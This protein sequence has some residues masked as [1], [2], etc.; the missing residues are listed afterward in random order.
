[1]AE[2]GI[3]F[4]GDMMRAIRA[5]SKTQ[6]RRPM[7]PQ[8]K[9]MLDRYHVNKDGH[10]Y[11]P[12]VPNSADKSRKSPYAVGDIL[13]CRETWKETNWMSYPGGMLCDYEGVRYRA[14]DE[15]R[16]P[17]CRGMVEYKGGVPNYEDNNWRPSIHM[18][19]EYARE[20]LKV[21]AVRAER[22]NDITEAGAVKEGFE[23][24]CDGRDC[25]CMGKGA[26]HGFYRTWQGVYPD[27]WARNDWVWVTE[28][29][30]TEHN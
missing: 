23:Q 3:L 19:K 6:T 15:L 1:M 25:G 22:V 9:W 11:T 13:Y 10:P 2:K 18:P 28:F 27:S 8:P 17:M 14:D 26:T 7:K 12:I 30:R 5:G 20:W 24:C 21:T 29:E 16:H 4:N